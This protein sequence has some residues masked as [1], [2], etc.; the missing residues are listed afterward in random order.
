ML[1]RVFMDY[2]VDWKSFFKDQ[3]KNI[4]TILC[5]V[6]FALLLLDLSRSDFNFNEAFK[7]IELFHIPVI[8]AIIIFS[9]LILA[10]FL[11]VFAKYSVITIKEDKLVGRNY[12]GVK[13]TISI[14]NIQ[15]AYKSDDRGIKSIV[16]SGGGFWN[17]IYISIFTF[18]L[19]RIIEVLENKGISII[20]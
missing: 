16:V 18:D 17:S 13:Q 14:S 4:L 9:S 19:D 20:E 7:H 8:A 15:K 11:S 10:L 1:Q 2:R 6:L 5:S 12:F 3:F